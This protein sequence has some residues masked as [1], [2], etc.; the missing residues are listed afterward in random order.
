MA[1][2]RDR[3][4]R[5]DQI[6][7]AVECHSALASSID[8]DSLLERSPSGPRRGQPRAA[9]CRVSAAGCAATHRR[10]AWRADWLCY[11]FINDG[12]KPSFVV[13]VSAFYERKRAALDCYRSPVRAI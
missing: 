13:D 6:R 12:A 11:Y 2:R 4:G 10:G 1:R 7:D 5:A 3:L 9:C 8:R